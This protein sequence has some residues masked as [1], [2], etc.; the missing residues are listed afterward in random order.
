[1]ASGKALDEINEICEITKANMSDPQCVIFRATRLLLELSRDF[2]MVPAAMNTML[3]KLNA[4][5]TAMPM[6]WRNDY[7]VIAASRMRGQSQGS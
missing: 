3:T 6:H 7:C 5:V 2:G 4:V 1:M